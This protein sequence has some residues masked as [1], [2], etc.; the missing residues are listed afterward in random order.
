MAKWVTRKDLQNRPVG[1]PLHGAE[2][3]K[4]VEAPDAPSVADCIQLLLSEDEICLSGAVRRQVLKGA[5]LVGY[6]ELSD[7]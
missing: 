3:D 6:I 4:L 1:E 5:R 7:T 2:A